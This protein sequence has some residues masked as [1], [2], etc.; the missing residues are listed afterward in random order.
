MYFD[1]GLGREVGPSFYPSV[2][3]SGQVDYIELLSPPRS[4]SLHQQPEAGTLT[5]VH[6]AV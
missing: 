4:S 1:G 5:L 3:G 6:S 2:G